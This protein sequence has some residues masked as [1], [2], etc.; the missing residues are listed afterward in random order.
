MSPRDRAR[1]PGGGGLTG[2]VALALLEAE[3]GAEHKGDRGGEGGEDDE[4]DGDDCEFLQLVRCERERDFGEQERGREQRHVELVQRLCVGWGQLPDSSCALPSNSGAT[5]SQRGARPSGRTFFA[6][7]STIPRR[8]RI[9]PTVQRKKT[10]RMLHPGAA[11]F[12]SAAGRELPRAR[13]SCLGIRERG[14]GARAHALTTT[15]MSAP[16]GFGPL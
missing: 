14:V 13:A 10:S 6:L 7:S 11:G 5:P 4:P 16:S 3:D 2:K 12:A 15:R 9:H 1:G 8:A